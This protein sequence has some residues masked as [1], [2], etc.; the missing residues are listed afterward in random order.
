MDMLN[1]SV[2]FIQSICALVCQATEAL[3]W[4]QVDKNFKK[5]SKRNAFVI[6]HLT[7]ARMHL[8]SALMNL[9]LWVNF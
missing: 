5:R 7:Y 4:E 1:I 6:L 3:S 2:G 9:L 8:E